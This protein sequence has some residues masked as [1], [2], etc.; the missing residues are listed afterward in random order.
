MKTAPARQGNKNKNEETPAIKFYESLVGVMNTTAVKIGS[1]VEL[2]GLVSAGHL[3]GRCG[4]VCGKKGEDR[5]MVEIEPAWDKVAV[6]PTNI[7]MISPEEVSEVLSTRREEMLSRQA[8]AR[9]VLQPD[10]NCGVQP[11]PSRIPSIMSEH[12]RK[13]VDLYSK[14]EFDAAFA[15]F[16][17]AVSSGDPSVWT[18][19][20][21]DVF[22]VQC[23]SNS[24]LC[25][26]KL[27]RPAEAR[28][29]C[30]TALTLPSAY[31]GDVALRNKLQRT[32]LQS[33]IDMK[34]PI[35]DIRSLIVQQMKLGMFGPSVPSSELVKHM[36]TIASVNASTTD[37]VAD[38]NIERAFDV[39]VD[40]WVSIP[41]VT[42]EDISMARRNISRYKSGSQRDEAILKNVC[43]L[44]SILSA[45]STPL[46]SL[47]SNVFTLFQVIDERPDIDLDRFLESNL[48][49]ELRRRALHLSE[50]DGEKKCTLLWGAASA[51]CAAPR[52]SPR[53]VGLFVAFVELLVDVCGA[54]VDQTTKER[55]AT[56]LHYAIQ[57]CQ[58]RA[59]RALLSRGAS[60]HA[61]DNEGWTPL[62]CSLQNGIKPSS[63][64]GPTSEDR[65]AA[66][67][68]LWCANKRNQRCWH[69]ASAAGSSYS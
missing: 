25:L 67:R 23:Y 62:M 64:G 15:E 61:R 16:C 14:L 32:L 29:N 19:P 28:A 38:S 60:P 65:V 44:G 50:G 2:Q 35:E 68:A 49:T 48:A 26:L 9:S 58:E 3:N 8:V 46:F 42:D 37:D 63:E 1:Q 52:F 69:N 31:G 57:S 4:I 40:L 21:V 54:P 33:T 55:S 6:K 45:R 51:L 10:D 30:L 20:E 24:A 56:P 7:K 41:A 12:K 66:T 5:I 11:I 39:L 18:W 59:V 36:K 47:I 43:A 53:T 34:A 22:I 27:G 13:G 17:L